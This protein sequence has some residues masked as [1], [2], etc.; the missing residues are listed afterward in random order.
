MTA[1][2]LL[3]PYD[4]ASIPDAPAVFLI[5]L[6]QGR[7]YLARTARLRRRLA[8][9]LSPPTSSSRRLNLHSLAASVEYHL[10]PSRLSSSLTFYRLAQAHFP[11]EYLNFLK[12]RPAPFVKLILSNPFPRT[13]V[14]TRLSSSQALHYGPFRSR[15]SAERFEQDLL[16][17]FQVRRCQEDL[18]PSPDHPGC[19]Y[20]EMMKCLRPCQQVVGPEEYRSEANRLSAFLSTQGHSLLEP[21]S[22]ARERASQDLDFEQAQRLHSRYLRIEQT[23]KLRDDLA[24]P[25]ESLSGAAVSPSPVPGEV[26]LFFFLQG[27]W[28]EPVHFPIAATSS[29][30]LPLDRR[31]RE[32]LPSL[33]FPRLTLR[34]RAEHISL[35][36]RWFYSSYRDSD[37][38]SFT[39]L[40]DIPYRRLVRAIS[41]AGRHASSAPG[42]APG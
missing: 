28:A 5:H 1:P 3:P 14:S 19:I 31:L 12:L 33:Q 6:H 11:G 9:L 17:L 8:R 20:G 10:T 2:S 38:F 35:L 15:A 27:A 26:Q 24:A 39:S 4:L 16:D 21:V 29:E 34:Q 7:P 32:L 37:W 30:V 23:L 13:A 40:D 41:G 25:L 22:S 18:I 36:A 42:P